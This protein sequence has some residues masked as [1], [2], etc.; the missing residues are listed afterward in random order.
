MTRT[1]C[2]SAGDGCESPNAYTSRNRCQAF[3][4]RVP[5]KVAETLHVVEIPEVLKCAFCLLSILCNFKLEFLD[6]LNG[7]VDCRWGEIV[8]ENGLDECK[9]FPITRQCIVGDDG[10]GVFVVDPLL[11]TFLGSLERLR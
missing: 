6:S 10:S 5:L 3:D 4:A 11:N 7:I 1:F 2:D 8:L 9:R